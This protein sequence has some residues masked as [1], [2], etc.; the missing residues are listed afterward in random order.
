LII[1]NSNIFI[2]TWSGFLIPAI[3]VSK[4]FARKRIRGVK[5]ATLGT[6]AGVGSTLFFFLWTN[7]GVWLLSTMYPKTISGLLLC[8]VRALPFLRMQT[9][10]TL[11]FVPAGFFLVEIAKKYHFEER[12]LKI[13]TSKSQLR[14]VKD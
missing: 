7:F 4:V 11:I 6:L 5:R 2:F 1:G 13:F 14:F 3:F 9:I 12:L 10:S 8:Y